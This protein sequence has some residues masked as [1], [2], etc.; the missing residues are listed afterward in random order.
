MTSVRR[1]MIVR[2]LAATM[3]VGTAV[4]PAPALASTDGNHVFQWNPERPGTVVSK[5]AATLPDELRRLGDAVRI[6]YVTTDVRGRS[7]TATGLVIT[8]KER[9]KN[10][11]VA[12]AHGTVGLADQCAPS[13]N[14]QAF[15]PEARTAVGEL[16]RRGWTVAAPDYPGIGTSDPHPYLIGNSE[17]RSIID[18][19]RAARHL[20]DDLTPQYVVDG[21]SQGGQAA[22]FANQLAG[23]YDRELQLRGTVSIAPTSGVRTLAELIPQSEGKGYLVM[24]LFGLNAVEPSFKPADVLAAPAERRL[25]VLRT[26]CLYEIL[27][28]YAN[29]MP[30]QLLNNGT[31]P[32]RWVDEL[33]KYVEP[34]QTRTTAPVFIVQGADDATVPAALTDALVQRLRDQN[35]VVRYDTLPGQDH[36]TAVTVSA[37]RVANWIAQRF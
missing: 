14:Q 11:T 31:L 16:L 4:A 15:Y 25:G 36:D 24:A 3:V 7:I 9:R 21:H 8:P 22:L 27:G 5:A 2:L 26:G 20:D 28:A 12:W 1:Q 19:V 33:Y 13:T 30:S 18:S 32:E 23:S 34:A 6:T 10:K 35:A 29:L 37:E 17:G